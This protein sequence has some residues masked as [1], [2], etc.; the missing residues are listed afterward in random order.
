MKPEPSIFDEPDLEADERAMLEG[1][2][3]ADAGRVIPHELV[4]EWLSRWGTPEETP[5]PAEWLKR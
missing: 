2:A 1:E 5:M 3:D 4:A